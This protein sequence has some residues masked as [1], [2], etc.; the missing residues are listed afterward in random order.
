M[1]NV[2]IV[3]I[4]GDYNYL[5]VIDYKFG[6]EVKTMTKKE[7]LTRFI[8]SR[9]Y[10]EKQNCVC[11]GQNNKCKNGFSPVIH[12]NQEIKKIN[13]HRADKLTY[14]L[15]FPYCKDCK[16][17]EVDDLPFFNLMSPRKLTDEEF[18]QGSKNADWD[19]FGK[20]KEQVLFFRFVD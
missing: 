14:D 4:I 18:A 2:I 20:T 1:F 19:K 16:Q 12:F 8:L 13:V 7:C 5:E 11:Y 17:C 9:F 3:Q 15:M 6:K 10:N